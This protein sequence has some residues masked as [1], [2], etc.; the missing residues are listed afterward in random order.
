MKKVEAST[1]CELTNC[2]EITVVDHDIVYVCAFR[3]HS[4]TV[5]VVD[6]GSIH[7]MVY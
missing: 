1:N 3:I 5:L 4:P 2:N 6:P 7:M